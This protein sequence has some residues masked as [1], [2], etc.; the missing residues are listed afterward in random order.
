MLDKDFL[1][2][3]RVYCMP[4]SSSAEGGCNLSSARLRA[5]FATK[6]QALVQQYFPGSRHLDLPAS[7]GDV[8]LAA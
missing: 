6:T 3:N 2:L 4:L 1:A 5:S 7:S 8:K